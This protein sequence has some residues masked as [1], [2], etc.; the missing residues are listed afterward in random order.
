MS[1]NWIRI[2]RRSLLVIGAVLAAMLV[3]WPEP[4]L[5]QCAMCKETLAN[6]PEAAAAAK[7]FNLGILV[8]LIPP[9][10]MF[11]GIFGMIY[12]SAKPRGEDSE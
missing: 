9:V 5:A 11:V 3:L 8:L 2:C 4:T 1:L 12:R 6:S 7:R 10:A